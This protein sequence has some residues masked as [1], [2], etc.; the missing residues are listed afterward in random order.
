M[1]DKQCSKLKIKGKTYTEP[2][3]QKTVRDKY[4]QNKRENV[5]ILDKKFPKK[6]QKCITYCVWS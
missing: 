4:Y 6:M 3:W 1:S 5:S 2:V